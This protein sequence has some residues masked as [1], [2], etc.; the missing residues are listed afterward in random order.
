MDNFRAFHTDSVSLELARS[1]NLEQSYLWDQIVGC[2]E[3]IAAL[4]QVAEGDLTL[5]GV[6][7]LCL[8]DILGAKGKI[9]EPIWVLLALQRESCHLLTQEVL[10]KIKPKLECIQ[11]K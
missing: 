9:Q 4:I 5:A 11:L 3:G 2:L 10:Q 8:E 6:D 1:V 7:F